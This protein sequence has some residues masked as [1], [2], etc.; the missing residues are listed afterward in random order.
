[1]DKVEVAIIG[2][3]V[4]GLA[5]AGKLID[6][7]AKVVVLEALPRIGGRIHSENF[8]DGY[9]NVGANWVGGEPLYSLARE[10][11]L[12]VDD[13]PFR[14]IHYLLADGQIVDGQRSREIASK[15]KQFAVDW[16]AMKAF[17]GNLGDYFAKRSVFS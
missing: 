12:I 8:G 2:A 17:D 14:H 1:M 5:A 16:E 9:V 15:I 6:S 7:G 11:D 13:A 3:G 4:A 10:E